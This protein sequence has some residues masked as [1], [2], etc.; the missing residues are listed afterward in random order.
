[1]RSLSHAWAFATTLCVHGASIGAGTIQH[2]PAR[3]TID[4]DEEMTGPALHGI[5]QYCQAL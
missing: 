5:D 1:M 4:V 3:P 2:T